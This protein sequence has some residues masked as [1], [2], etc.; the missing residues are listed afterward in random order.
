MKA[1][2]LLSAP[3]PSTPAAP[4]LR[5]AIVSAVRFWERRRISYNIVLTALVISWVVFTWPHFRA[6]VTLP[7]V[8]LA[9]AYMLFLA[10]L[11]NLCYCA[12]Y[13]VDFVL[14][15]YTMPE[16]LRCS[17]TVFWWAGMILA[18]ALAYYWIGDEIYSS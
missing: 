14:Q 11:A 4:S 18:F 17:R 7:Y 5:E 15:L 3:N 1:S 10:V 12:A 6:A 8:F 9:L 16:F 2:P 13:P